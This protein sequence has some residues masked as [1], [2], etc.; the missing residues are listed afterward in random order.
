MQNSPITIA[1]IA[2]PPN[3]IPTIAPVVSPECPDVGVDELASGELEGF[4]VFDRHAEVKV[5]GIIVLAGESVAIADEA[6][7]EV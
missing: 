6:A 5:G 3:A 4:G 2:T 7:S 1:T